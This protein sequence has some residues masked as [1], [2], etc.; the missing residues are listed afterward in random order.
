MTRLAQSLGFAGFDALRRP[1]QRALA[2]RSGAA[3]GGGYVDRMQAQRSAGP[4][5]PLAAAQQAAVS[6]VPAHNG[7]PAI[8][9]AADLLLGARQVL[10]LG[11]RASFGIAYHLHY[12]YQLLA[13][14][15]GLAND[16]AGTLG[17]RLL[18]LER[19][20]LLVAVSQAPYTRATVEAVQRASGAGVPVLALTDSALSPIAR[21][22]ARV[23]VFDAESPSFFQSMTGAQA[24]AETL[25]A[26]VAVRGGDAVL[27]RLQRM[28]SH[29]QRQRAYWER[30][31]RRSAE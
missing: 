1:F 24:L 7:A 12:T 16:A 13:G 22:A 3:D 20:D 11:L 17:D 25:I 5:A 30:P 9:A 26:A 4:A 10:F 23:L 2:A 8:E 27:Q 15:G 28:Q 31:R 18:Q 29:L 19:E 21:P 14:N 6:S